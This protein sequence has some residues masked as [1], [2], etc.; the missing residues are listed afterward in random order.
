MSW[1]RTI[2]GE[3]AAYQ[4]GGGPED[5]QRREALRQLVEQLEQLLPEPAVERSAPE[6]L[7]AALPELA[8]RHPVVAALVRSLERGPSR[9]LRR[10]RLSQ[11]QGS[12]PDVP[13]DCPGWPGPFDVPIRILFF[14]ADPDPQR[15]V[16]ID[17]EFRAIR[18]ALW[19][20]DR[21]LFELEPHPAGSVGELQESL[22]RHRPH[23]LHF[24]GHGEDEALLVD[25]GGGSRRVPAAAFAAL[26]GHFQTRGLCCVFL[27]ACHS[28]QQAREIA[29]SID[30]VV[31]MSRTIDDREAIAFATAF[32]LSLAY[33]RERDVVAAFELA[34]NRLA[35]DRS[36]ESEVPRLFCRSR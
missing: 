25:D 12:W 16:R 24:S 27:N 28:E 34:C 29:R 31:G 23:I 9:D 33:D 32:Y 18:E 10:R 1:A 8:D 13:D 7:V 5:P 20:G 4:R 14:G 30:Y 15:P 22:L 17:R 35:L 3:V 11:T 19:R 21:H 6:P 36:S 2:A 26:V